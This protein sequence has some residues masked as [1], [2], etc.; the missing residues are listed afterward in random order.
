[1]TNILDKWLR[2][3][4]KIS[5]RKPGEK[6]R[7]PCRKQVVLLQNSGQK[8]L[9]TSWSNKWRLFK[10]ASCLATNFLQ[11]TESFAT[12]KWCKN[13]RFVDYS[14]SSVVFWCSIRNKVIICIKRFHLDIDLCVCPRKKST[15]IN[16]LSFQTLGLYLQLWTEFNFVSFMCRV[17]YL[18]GG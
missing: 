18:V 3:L 2:K 12:Y 1:M 16:L 5:T 10:M 9:G 13:Y 17:I 11:T 6:K 7:S 8:D 15:E 14:R 4:C